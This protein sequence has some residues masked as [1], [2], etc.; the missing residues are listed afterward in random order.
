M[1]STRSS[2]AVVSP[3][4]LVT[5]SNRT[6]TS[7]PPSATA[8][9]TDPACPSVTI[10]PRRASCWE[11][12]APTIFRTLP[13]GGPPR[14][15]QAVESAGRRLY[16]A[17]AGLPCLHGGERPFALRQV[18]PVVPGDLREQDPVARRPPLGVEPFAFPLGLRGPGPQ[19]QV[20]P[21]ERAER[22][23]HRGRIA[24]R[25]PEPP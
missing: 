14:N 9:V 10:V 12:P 20:R 17:G 22:V 19:L 6:S 25:V 16:E 2:T 18:E 8:A 15:G 3:K 7:G 5:R 11:E 21:P 1:S 23:Q 24:L 4:R 13:A